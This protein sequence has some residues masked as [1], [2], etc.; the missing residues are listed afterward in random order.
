LGLA[1]DEPTDAAKT[2]TINEIELLI[3]DHVLPVA[4]QHQVDYIDSRFGRG[5]SIAPVTGG[6]G[7]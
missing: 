1:L 3:D 2:Y 6:N 5:F 7:C 4:R